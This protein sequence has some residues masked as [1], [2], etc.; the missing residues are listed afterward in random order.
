MTSAT[1]LGGGAAV[2]LC[3]LYVNLTRRA[4]VTTHPPAHGKACRVC[5]KRAVRELLVELVARIC[6]SVHRA[7]SRLRH[8]PD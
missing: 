7:E 5:R 8:K 3:K 4:S 2:V 1:T 6:L